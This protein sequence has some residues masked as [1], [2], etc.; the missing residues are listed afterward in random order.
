MSPLEFYFQD[1]G[2]FLCYSTKINDGFGHKSWKAERVFLL[3]LHAGGCRMGSAQR[4]TETSVLS[5][6]YDADYD[7]GKILL[8]YHLYLQIMFAPCLQWSG[9]GGKDA[10]FGWEQTQG[11]Y[12]GLN[13]HTTFKETVFGCI[14][15]LIFIYI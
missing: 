11:S 1:H 3:R 7:K 6:L 12:L 8:S 13:F 14:D 9:G 15:R 5:C 4:L 10:E 2:S